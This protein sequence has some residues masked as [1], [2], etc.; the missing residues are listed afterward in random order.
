MK[1]DI[2][3]VKIRLGKE[4]W[5]MLIFELVFGDCVFFGIEDRVWGFKRRNEGLWIKFF[6]FKGYEFFGVVDWKS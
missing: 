6:I 1:E 3:I 5:D 2:G 4:Y